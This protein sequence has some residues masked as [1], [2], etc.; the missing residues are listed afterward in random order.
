[1]GR[2]FSERSKDTKRA[3]PW[4]LRPHA[5]ART[6]GGKLK[7]AHKHKMKVSCKNGQLRLCCDHCNSQCFKSLK[8][9][10]L[11]PVDIQTHMIKV[12]NELDNRTIT[13][14][15]HYPEELRVARPHSASH[16]LVRFGT[17]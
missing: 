15:A 8:L 2:R 5:R 12:F 1:V 9:P 3:G 4:S 7:N 13:L 16:K 6:S 10:A 17:C 11:G 14:T